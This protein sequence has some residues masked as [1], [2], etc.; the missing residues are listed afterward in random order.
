MAH[1]VGWK[2][3][4]VVSTLEVKR[5]VKSEA[6][7]KKKL[8]MVLRGGDTSAVNGNGTNGAA[9]FRELSLNTQNTLFQESLVGL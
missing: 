7:Y 2:Y 5:K 6:F 9:E 8:A 4:D 1:E 3:Q